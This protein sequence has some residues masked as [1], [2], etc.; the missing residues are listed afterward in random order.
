MN[1]PMLLGDIP[2]LFHR[3]S[4]VR[5]IPTASTP[6]ATGV[7]AGIHPWGARVAVDAGTE[8]YFNSDETVM[9]DDLALDLSDATGR[10]HATWWLASKLFKA[11]GARPELTVFRRCGNGW[12]LTSYD[13]AHHPQSWT[14]T[15]LG[16][17]V[18]D[19][20]YLHLP[21]GS[22][23]IDAEAIRCAVLRVFTELK[24]A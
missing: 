2:G 11:P 24:A 13:G 8:D 7:I 21:D 10:A 4:P 14:D 20:R 15:D 22:P 23:W 12:E 3:G 18:N 9:L 6:G 17:N 5:I 19:H 1:I 16:L